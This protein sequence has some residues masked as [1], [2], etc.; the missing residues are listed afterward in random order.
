M[1]VSAD[2]QLG[3]GIFEAVRV[4]GGE[5]RAGRR[6][7]ARLQASARALGLP[8][9]DEAA[10]LQ[11]VAQAT[12]EGEMVR[13]TLHDDDGRPSLV[14]TRRAA[15]PSARLRLI[16]LPGWYARGYRL[17]EHKLTSHFHGARGRAVAASRGVDDALLVEESSGL[18]GE[19]SNANVFAVIDGV[20]VTPAVDGLLPGI[21]RAVC[22]EVL[23]GLGFDVEQRPLELGELAGCEGVLISASGRG[24]TPAES[25]DGVALAQPAAELLDALA[26]AVQRAKIASALPLPLP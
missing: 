10:F 12:G 7:V 16:S 20:F 15:V 23:P 18:V 3:G 5:V 2:Q 14:G 19:A 11:A 26:D 4:S 22:L 6:H 13:V 24:L 9:P 25:L 1:T 8:V 17:R 21:T